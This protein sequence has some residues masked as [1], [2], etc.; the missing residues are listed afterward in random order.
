MIGKAINPAFISDGATLGLLEA[1]AG[2][3]DSRDTMESALYFPHRDESR[4][5]MFAILLVAAAVAALHVVWLPRI[6]VD[7]AFISYRYARNLV[8]GRGLVFNAG[9]RVEGFSNFLWV[10]LTAIGMKFGLD[11]IAWTRAIGASC[12]I[13]IVLVAT[14]IG[15]NLTRSSAGALGVALILG[16]STALCGSALSG[17]ETGLYG[18]LLILALWMTG[19]RRLLTASWCLGLAAL[20]R[21]EGVGI[22]ALTTAF[23]VLRVLWKR[24]SWGDAIRLAA[25]AS[26]MI[27][28]LMG[29]RLIYYG[30]WVPNSVAAKS[31]MLTLFSQADWPGRFKLIF[32]RAGWGYVFAFIRYAFGPVVVLG[33]VAAVRGMMKELRGGASGGLNFARSATRGRVSRDDRSAVLCL[34]AAYVTMAFAVSIYNFGDWMS[35]FRLLTPYLAPLTLLVVMGMK[36]TLIGIRQWNR[37]WVRLARLAIALST[38]YCAAG[39]FQW[40]RSFAAGSPDLEIAS[41]LCESQQPALLASTDVLGRLGYYAPEV[42]VLDMAGLTDEHIA[43]SGEPKPPF[44]RS[45]FGYVL[46]ERP[47]FIMNNVRSAWHR[48]LDR[49]EFTEN[50]WWVDRPAWTSLAASRGKPR[51]VFVERGSV[52]E[53]EMRRR[54]PDANFRSPAEIASGPALAAGHQR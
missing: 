6:I 46:S 22:V 20:T 39:Q 16:G 19:H 14:A 26:V 30:H 9:E 43:R 28:G 18:F 17:L 53:G 8:E 21:P 15:K 24:S 52:I 29:F 11:P 37:R 13:G 45:D 7:D 38:V 48:H 12:Y 47:Q 2:R 49:R 4:R 23:F 54:F 36:L 31:A 25:P 32:N 51:Y 33:A 41:F 42:P 35:S 27:A 3:S 5:A 34:S 40:K 10:V 44:G 1:V 50:Y